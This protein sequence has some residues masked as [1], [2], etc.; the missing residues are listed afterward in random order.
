[1]PIFVLFVYIERF[2]GAPGYVSVGY[3]SARPL[4]SV[5]IV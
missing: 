3:Y 2:N 1:M 4:Y 5:K